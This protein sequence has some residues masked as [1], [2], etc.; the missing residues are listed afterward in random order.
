MITLHNIDTD[1]PLGTI[2]EADLQILIDVLEEE[3]SEDRD[4]F[5]D[6]PTVDLLEQRGATAPLVALLRGAIGGSEGVEIRW[7]RT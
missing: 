6:E 7:D 5:I 2:S 3:S 1:T 4:Y